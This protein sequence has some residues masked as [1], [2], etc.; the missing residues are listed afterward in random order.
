[1]SLCIAL[2]V[3]SC[4]SDDSSGSVSGTTGTLLKT[5]K[6]YNNSGVLETTST[7]EYN[8]AGAITKITIL[9]YG[10][11]NE[12]LFN[13]DGN[14]DLIDW[15]EYDN[16]YETEETNIAEY[17]NGLIVGACI[18]RVST[19]GSGS[20]YDETDKIE[21]E[22]DANGNTTTYVHYYYELSIPGSPVI[23]CADVVSESNNEALEYDALGNMIRYENSESFF[24]PSYSTYVYD[25]QNH[26]YKNCGSAVWRKLLGFSS[27]NN[28]VSSNIYDADTDVLTA[29]V[30]FNNVYNSL[31]YPTRLE[32]L[33]QDVSGGLSQTTVFEYTYY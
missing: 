11:A 24:G 27:V 21:F 7:Y 17:E 31:G 5:S 18:D 14:G 15:V 6:K 13:Y 12:V 19:G 1:M 4:S 26:P 10:I 2:F 20:S 16:I 23:T 3:A 30:T 32:K 22:Y 9:N 33:Y 28:I 29:T 25:N 8:A